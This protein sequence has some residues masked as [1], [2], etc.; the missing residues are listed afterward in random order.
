MTFVQR[1]TR[2][3]KKN[4]RT[5]L[6]FFDFDLKYR[7]F[8]QTTLKRT[9]SHRSCVKISV[10]NFRIQQSP[11]KL[12]KSV[13]SRLEPDEANPRYQIIDW[14]SSLSRTLSDSEIEHG[15][16]F[17]QLMAP[18]SLEGALTELFALQVNME[19]NSNLSLILFSRLCSPFDESPVISGM[20]KYWNSFPAETWSMRT[21]RKLR[22]TIRYIFTLEW[23]FPLLFAIN[24]QHQYII[25]N[26]LCSDSWAVRL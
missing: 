5:F 12:G 21:A 1:K 9:S 2:L 6:V 7:H 18:S 16:F 15:N 25:M 20:T 19:E 10:F 22:N 14:L 4:E 13:N 11:A 8:S 26:P 23:F 24:I 17:A 3:R